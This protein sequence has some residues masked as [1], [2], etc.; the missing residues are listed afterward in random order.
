MLSAMALVKISLCV[1]LLFCAGLESLS[2]FAGNDSALFPKAF[3][4]LGS[5]S[6]TKGMYR[7][8]VLP[9]GGW[10]SL[11]NLHMGAVSVMNY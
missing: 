1:L 11:R 4:D 2:V 3:L 5:C 9:G 10:D 8:E 7:F 6:L